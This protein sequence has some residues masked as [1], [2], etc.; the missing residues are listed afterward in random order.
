MK[1]KHAPLTLFVLSALMFLVGSSVL[2]AGQ[3][4]KAPAAAP[5]KAATAK[6]AAPAAVKAPAAV[7]D[8]FKKAYPNAQVKSVSSEKEDGKV[9]YELEMV[10]GGVTRNV[11]Y[12]VDGKLVATEDGITAAQLPKVVSDA[13]MKKY[14]KGT[15]SEV[16]KVLSAA[17]VTSY[18]MVVTNAGKKTTVEV[19]DKGKIQ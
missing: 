14:P 6:A 18:E 7:L 8:A 3:A 19:D 1:T 13:V 16:E 15:L 11:I 9:Q 5:A 17:G 12:T 2:L 4:A 10:D